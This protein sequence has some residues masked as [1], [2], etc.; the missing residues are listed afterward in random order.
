[1]R[2]M[3]HKYMSYLS[4]F[5]RYNEF[6]ATKHPVYLCIFI[7]F[8]C[9]CYFNIFFYLFES[10]QCESPSRKFFHQ[11]RLRPF[12][13]AEFQGSSSVAPI[14]QTKWK[15]IDAAKKGTFLLARKWRRLL[16]ERVT[17]VCVRNRLQRWS[18][19]KI[20]MQLWK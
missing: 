1:M 20:I 10:K 8:I 3:S 6:W 2:K 14:L 18:C 13:K 7:Y 9:I 15:R 12:V 19:G 16:H 11:R 17:K 5:M 4:S